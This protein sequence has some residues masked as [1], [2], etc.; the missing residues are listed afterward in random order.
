MKKGRT[1]MFAVLGVM[2]FLLSQA[3]GGDMRSAEGDLPPADAK[4]FWTYI[5]KTNPYKGW[6]Y[7]P[8]HYGM[9]PGRTPH[10]AFLVLYANP[11]ALRAAREGKPMPEG[12]ILIKENYAKDKKTL[13][14]LTPMYKVKGYNPE[15]GDWFWVKYTPGGKVE[16]AG[17]PKGCINCH[18][19]V[20]DN[21]WIFTPTE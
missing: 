19:A 21:S 2:V 8:G 3:G 16:K 15:G 5:T 9:Y 13:M 4:A 1:I 12:A 7:W 18:E 11:I 10:G 6:G 14:A 20:K 17:K